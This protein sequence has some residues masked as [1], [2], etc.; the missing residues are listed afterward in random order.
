VIFIYGNELN[1]TF[2][3]KMGQFLSSLLFIFKS[4][5]VFNRCKEPGAAP[6]Q[7]IPALKV[8]EILHM[9]SRRNIYFFSGKQCILS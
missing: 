3:N 1:F 6:Y 9:V 5:K 7:P 2:I 4:E 8:K